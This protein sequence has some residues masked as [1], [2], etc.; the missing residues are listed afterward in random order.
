MHH[1][2]PRA[3]VPLSCRISTSLSQALER[4]RRET[5]ESVG[6]IVRH[7][8][9]EY[10]Q[11]DHATLFQVS[12]AGALVEGIYGGDV[13]IGLLREHGD[14]GLGTFVNLDGEMVVLD[15]HFYQVRDDGT[16]SEASDEE[17]SP[18]AM[19]TR[20]SEPNE[21]KSVENCDSLAQLEAEIDAFRDS[22]N[23]FYSVHVQGMFTSMRTRTVRLTPEGVPLVEA[24]SNQ[25][26]FEF[27]NVRGSLVGFWSPSYMQ[28][29]LV[30]GYHLHFLSEDRTLGGHLLDCAGEDLRVAVRREADFRLSLPE[31][32][33]FLHADLTRDPSE[34][35][36]RAEKSHD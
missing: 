19:I 22:A 26:E 4:R 8:L 23:V 12:T 32:V 33:S 25:R 16:V 3:A 7:A 34:D 14:F 24:A 36:D 5:G 2:N 20:F 10:L 27:A 6:H 35:L 31:S 29:V 30:A 13:T 15:G 28:S 1:D 18:Y 9:A 17:M 21:W 11:V